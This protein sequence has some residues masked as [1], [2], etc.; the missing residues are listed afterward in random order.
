MPSVSQKRPLLFGAMLNPRKNSL[1]LIRLVLAS[2]VLLH[3]SWP[4]TGT[5]NGWFF[6]GDYLGGWAVAGFFAISGYL[7]TGSRWANRLGDYLVHRTARIMPAFL[8]CLLVMVAFFGPISYL[9]SKGSLSGYFSSATSPL[10]FLISNITLKM[11]NYDIAGSPFDVPYPGAWNGSLW[12]LYYEFLCYLILAFFGLFVIFKRSV[13]PITAAFVLSVVVQANMGF[14]AYHSHDNGDLISL[15]KLLPFFLG[16]ATLFVWKNRIGLH[17]LPAI[18]SLGLWV[19]L[20]AAFPSWGGQ[21]SGFFAAYFLLW[22]SSWLPQPAWIA[23]NDVSYGMYIYAFPVQQLFAIFGAYHWGV[24]WFTVATLIATVPLAVAS[25]FWV[26]KP[27]MG[28]AKA[29][30]AVQLK[31]PEQVSTG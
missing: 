13:W 23:R 26:E 14:F 16:G 17:W 20:S 30:K 18:V 15:F 2:S 25:W 31:A 3:H 24:F 22:L 9:V 6:A 28:R 1:N 10:N 27:I 29:A 21:A 4:L 5:P 19:S 7:I 11:Y 8:V 12:T